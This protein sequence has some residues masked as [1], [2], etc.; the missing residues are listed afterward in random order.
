[1]TLGKS[2]SG[3]LVLWHSAISRLAR[4]GTVHFERVEPQECVVGNAELSISH[5]VQ[6]EHWLME[7]AYS[8]ELDACTHLLHQA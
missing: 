3:H 5:A 1:V 4:A 8:Q 2:G 7:G 6:L